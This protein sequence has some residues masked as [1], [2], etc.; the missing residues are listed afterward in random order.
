MSLE[1]LLEEVRV[2]GDITNRGVW[3]YL[4]ILTR[5]RQSHPPVRDT[6]G[7]AEEL[8]EVLSGLAAVR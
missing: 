3:Y 6:R 1:E 2:P 7:I 8:S 5:Y 4:K